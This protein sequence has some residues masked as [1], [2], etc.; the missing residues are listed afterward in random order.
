MLSWH[1]IEILIL[2]TWRLE[3]QLR[4]L[5]VQNYI[6]RKVTLYGISIIDHS[7]IKLKLLYIISLNKTYGIIKCD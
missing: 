1:V 5:L 2:I 7:F 6:A 3:N 4:I